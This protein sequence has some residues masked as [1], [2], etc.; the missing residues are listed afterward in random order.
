MGVVCVN[1]FV[2]EELA[3]VRERAEGTRAV[4]DAD[5]TSPVRREAATGFDAF[6]ESRWHGAVRLGHAILGSANVAEEIA[7]EAFVRV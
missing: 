4:R 6:Y 2:A 3:V 1:M 7:Q 5:T